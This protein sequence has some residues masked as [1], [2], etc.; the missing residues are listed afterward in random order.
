MSGR[1]RHRHRGA[2]PALADA[3]MRQ[4]VDRINRLESDL[5]EQA[6][7]MENMIRHGRIT[8]VDPEKGLYRQ[9]IGMD[10]DGTPQ[11][12]PWVRYAQHAGPLKGH[13][14]PAVGQSM[15]LFSPGG[16]VEQGIGHAYGWNKANPS[17]GSTSDHVFT[18]LDKI[19]ITIADG[20]VVATIPETTFRVDDDHAFTLDKSGMTH[21]GPVQARPDKNSPPKTID[22]THKHGGVTPGGAETDVPA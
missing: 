6:R 13:V 11:K 21:T 2:S 7:R 10:A 19:K 9:E 5:A 3:R 14:V 15:T 16:D 12:S 4:F 1:G 20:K 18:Y 17:P 22:H 8:D